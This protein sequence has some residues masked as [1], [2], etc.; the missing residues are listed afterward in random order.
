MNN[1]TNKQ[2]LMDTDTGFLVTTSGGEFTTQHTD[3]I[4]LNCALETYIILLT[5]AISTNLIKK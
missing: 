3:D 4:S 1:K 2:T 5:D